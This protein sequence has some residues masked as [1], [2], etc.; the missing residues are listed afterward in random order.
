MTLSL[1]ERAALI[2]LLAASAWLFWRRF[3]RVF[4]IIQKAR[5]DATW[6][7]H[8]IGKRVGRFL[9]EVALQSKVIQQRPLPGLA[10]AFVFWG[11]CVFA[12]VT[13]NHLAVGFGGRFLSAGSA[14]FVA[15]GVFAVA[16]AVSIAG[17]FVRRF[18]VRP[19]WLGPLS[20]E[21]GVI[22]A[23]I[24]VLMITYLATF[25]VAETDPAA[26]PLWWS[27]TLALIVFLPLIPH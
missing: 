8:P 2:V 27:H 17:L 11:F 15:A 10:H 19:V 9:S 16:V 25:A 21:S 23:L 24:F 22:A 7:L 6:K 1:P 14:Y 18:F 5:P 12:L 4:R 3:G 13:L 26:K 20:Y